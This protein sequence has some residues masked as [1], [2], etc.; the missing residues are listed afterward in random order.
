MNTSDNWPR[1]NKKITYKKGED[2]LKHIHNSDQAKASSK[3]DGSAGLCPNTI[4]LRQAREI[5]QSGIPEF[6]KTSPD[7][8][9]RIFAYHAGAIYAAR[10]QDGG[11]SWHAYPVKTGIPEKIINQ[12]KEENQSERRLIKKWLSQ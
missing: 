11:H 5:L 10:T 2:R 3:A 1:P 9:Y 7:K 12:I 4:S 6:R 8:P